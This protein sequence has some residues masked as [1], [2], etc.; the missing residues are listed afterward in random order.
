MKAELRKGWCPSALRPMESGD[1]LI[2][3]LGQKRKY[4]V[5]GKS[6]RTRRSCEMLR[7]WVV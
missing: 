6:A 7:Q 2:V 5:A 1:G 4:L 3:R